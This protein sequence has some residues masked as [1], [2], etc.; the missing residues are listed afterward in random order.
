MKD[1]TTLPWWQ[2]V[3]LGVFVGAAGLAFILW[4]RDRS[5]R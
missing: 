4:V 2:L 5:K 3:A 1:L